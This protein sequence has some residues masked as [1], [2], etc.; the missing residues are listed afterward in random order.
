MILN[1]ESNLPTVLKEPD[2][3][4]DAEITRNWHMRGFIS[5]SC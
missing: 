3:Q 4:R 2:C 5:H 1:L